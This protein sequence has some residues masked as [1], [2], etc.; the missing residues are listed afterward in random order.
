MQA[1]DIAAA[2][3]GTV[4]AARF[5]IGVESDVSW[6]QHC[7]DVFG[8]VDAYQPARFNE[9]PHTLRPFYDD[10]AA[11]AEACAPQNGAYQPTAVA[12]GRWRAHVTEVEATNARRLEV[13]ADVVARLKEMRD[14]AVD[15]KQVDDLIRSVS[16]FIYAHYRTV[17]P[18]GAKLRLW[19]TKATRR[20]DLLPGEWRVL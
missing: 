5:T 19:C 11:L 4:L 15:P 18:D 2:V 13:L 17:P 12:L 8:N 10:L 6:W 1:S 9:P 20:Y 14:R 16:T 7:V 3:P